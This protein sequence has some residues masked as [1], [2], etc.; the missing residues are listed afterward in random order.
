MAIDLTTHSLRKSLTSGNFLALLK[1]QPCAIFFFLSLDQLQLT[2]PIY[3]SKE[4]QPQGNEIKVK[5]SAS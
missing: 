4:P 1:K 3:P 2:F 5:Y